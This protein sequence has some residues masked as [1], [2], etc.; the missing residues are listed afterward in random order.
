MKKLTFLLIALL[1]V[2]TAGAQ[3]IEGTWLFT[4]VVVKDKIHEP[5]TV[6]EFNANGFIITQG[7]HVGS[8]LHNQKE[9]KLIMKTNHDKDFDGECKIIS[10]TKKELRFDKAGEKWFLSKLDSDEIARN[11]SKSGLIGTWKFAKDA[12]TDTSKVLNFEAPDNFT[13]IEK[14]P[15][16]VSKNKG[17]WIYNQEEQSL[18]LIA[19]MEQISGKNKILKISKEELILE[20]E[21]TKIT[22]QKSKDKKIERLKF[23]ADE[24]SYDENDNYRYEKDKEKLPWNDSYQMLISLKDTRQLV[25]N[26]STLIENTK[27]LETKKL[28]ANVKANEENQKLSIDFIF[29]GYD[30]YNLPDDTTLPP[31]NFNFGIDNKL[32]PLKDLLYRLVGNEEIT[33]AAGTFNCT[34]LEAL[35]ASREIKYKLWMIDNKP[36][37][38]AKIIEDKSGMWGYYNSYELISLVKK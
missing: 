11:N 22:L 13:F 1:V 17:M 12:N 8:W 37:V 36:G 21:G 15:G 32:Y 30:R 2:V 7:I 27:T 23:S 29:Y 35:D 34:V 25:Y 26:Y 28:I 19:R 16:M 31:N 9:G 5:L 18:L 20:N 10:L 4:K 14:T 3:E 24:F 38:Y 6:I 33:T